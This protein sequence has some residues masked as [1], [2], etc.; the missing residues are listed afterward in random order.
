V[1]VTARVTVVDQVVDAASAT[2]RIRLELPNADHTIVAG[3]RC[4]V[5]L[6]D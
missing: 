6:P 2:F 1:G 3:V 5:R 4:R